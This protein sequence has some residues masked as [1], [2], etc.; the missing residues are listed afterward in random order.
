[1]I[2][3]AGARVIPGGSYA[4]EKMRD[5]AARIPDIGKTFTAMA[6]REKDRADDSRPSIEFY[7]SQD[8]LLLLL[9]VRAG[10]SKG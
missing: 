6:E 1:M 3:Y 4:R 2:D 7:R 5:W 8:E 9:P 10:A